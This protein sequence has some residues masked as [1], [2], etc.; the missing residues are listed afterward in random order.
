VSGQLSVTWRIRA[1]CV[2][3][4][5]PPLLRFASFGRV[6]AWLGSRVRAR[7]LPA[8]DWT[9]PRWRAGWTA[10]SGDSPAPGTTAA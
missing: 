4:V 5:V 3:L 8:R 9:T 6:V 1:A 2:A 7:A 10:Y